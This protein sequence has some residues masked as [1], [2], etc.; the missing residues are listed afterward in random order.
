MCGHDNS[1][2]EPAGPL[3]VRPHFSHKH[4]KIKKYWLGEEAQSAVYIDVKYLTY[5]QILPFHLQP[6]L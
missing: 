1:H 4:L 2:S 5:Y 6:L 3:R